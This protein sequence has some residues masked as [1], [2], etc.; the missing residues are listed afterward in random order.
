MR[1]LRYAQLK[2]TY[3]DGK[4]QL[5]RSNL[6]IKCFTFF[7]AHRDELAGKS[8]AYVIAV[9]LNTGE[10]IISATVIMST[11]GQMRRA[12]AEAYWNLITGGHAT[13]DKVA[14]ILY[15][16]EYN[17]QVHAAHCRRTHAH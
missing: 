5:N 12:A 7:E 2:L 9:M 11:S 13:E 4:N 6:F 15:F 16:M 14:S 17:Y 8:F 10:F 1:A 3:T